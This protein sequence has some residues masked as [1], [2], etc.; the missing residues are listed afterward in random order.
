[1]YK[2]QILGEAFTETFPPP[3]FRTFAAPLPERVTLHTEFH[4]KDRNALPVFFL[5]SM[6]PDFPYRDGTESNGRRTPAA[7]TKER[8][9]NV[10]RATSDGTFSPLDEKQM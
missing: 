4:I 8:A 2:R 7:F 6:E 5:C 1:M 3:L 10:V 9:T